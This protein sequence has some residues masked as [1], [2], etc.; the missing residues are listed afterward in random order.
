MGYN[1]SIIEA[2][3][4]DKEFRL[5]IKKLK[6]KIGEVKSV[7]NAFGRMAATWYYKDYVEHFNKEQG[8]D[9]KWQKW[10]PAYRKYMRK[11]GRGDNKI[12]QNTRKMFNSFNAKKWR[13][14]FGSIEFYNDSPYGAK[15][16][17]GQKGMPE[18]RFMWIS[19]WAM[20]NIIDGTLKLVTEEGE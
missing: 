2:D 10:S 5:A 12:L 13:K 19:E 7:E 1:D 9:G 20:K 18:R 8:P 3:L 14:R 15:H 17:Y 11:I 4:D 16:N 6:K